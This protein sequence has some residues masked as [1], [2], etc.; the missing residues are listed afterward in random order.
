MTAFREFITDLIRRAGVSTKFIAK[1]LTDEN[2]EKFQEAFTHSSYGKNNYEMWEWLGDTT[3]NDIVVKWLHAKHPRIVSVRWLTRLKHTLISKKTLSVFA[4]E[5]GF[6]E[7]IRYGPEFQELLD[8]IPHEKNKEYKTLLEDC[9]EA[10]IGVLVDVCDEGGRRGIGYSVAFKFLE[11]YLDTV[12]VSLDFN[13]AFDAK[14]RLKEI[15]DRLDW[16]FSNKSFIVE[17]LESIREDGSRYPYF[18]ARVIGYP[19]GDKTPKPTN[20]FVFPPGTGTTKLEAETKAC[21]EAI[22][23]MGSQFNI[24]PTTVSP[25]E[26]N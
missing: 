5:S 10:F 3:V 18:E 15:Y 21:E 17:M 24:Y 7:H 6:F 1:I 23:I 20:K 2:L 16:K 9:F 11:S 26:R 8:R 19:H 4:E 14:T 13:V 12:E 25:Y 22:Q